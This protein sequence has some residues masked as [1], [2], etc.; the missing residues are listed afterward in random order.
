MKYRFKSLA[1]YSLNGR[2]YKLG[3]ITEDK[4][5]AKRFHYLFEEVYE[6]G[7]NEDMGRKKL[8]KI[9]KKYNILV[10]RNTTTAQ[11]VD[12]INRKIKKNVK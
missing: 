2:E 3:D 12:K 9:A 11:L 8:L 4:L 1:P 7:I 5:L 10:G 6:D